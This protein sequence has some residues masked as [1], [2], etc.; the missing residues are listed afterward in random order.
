LLLSDENNVMIGY[1]NLIEVIVNDIK[2]FGVGNVC[3]NK[4]YERNGIGSIVMEISSYYARKFSKGTVLYC[5][6]ELIKFYEKNGYTLHVG[7]TYINGIR[8]HDVFMTKGS[9]IDCEENAYLDRAF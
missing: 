4:N 5:R 1:L 9:T 3:V 2:M 8:S 6:P 7:N